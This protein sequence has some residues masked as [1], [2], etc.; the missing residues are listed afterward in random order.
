MEYKFWYNRDLEPISLEE[1]GKL[2]ADIKA[3]QIALDEVED[4][5][6]STVFLVLDH[7]Y[8]PSQEKPLLFETMVF[9]TGTYSPV[10]MNRYHTEDEARRG[11]DDVVLALVRDPSRF[12]E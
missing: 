9:P 10:Y 7:S 3:R 1:A 12:D 11:H 5:T 8:V 6:V 2:M 4:K